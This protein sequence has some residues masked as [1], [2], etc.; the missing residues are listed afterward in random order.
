MGY[1]ANPA[2]TFPLAGLF[3]I[4]GIG[5]TVIT[6]VS[7]NWRRGF[8]GFNLHTKIMLTATPI[9]LLFGTIM[10]WLLER[11]NPATMGHLS[12]GGQ[13]LAAF[14]QSATARTA[15]FNKYLI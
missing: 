3:I 10:F 9:L 2:I 8:R 1:V 4:G 15:G 14:F 6:D 5:F 11:N 13:W 7:A 12:M